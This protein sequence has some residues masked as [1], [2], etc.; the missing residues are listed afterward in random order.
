[1]AQDA[2]LIFCLRGA[3][4]LRVYAAPAARYSLE[5]SPGHPTSPLDPVDREFLV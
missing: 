4:L 2:L 3:P 1:M 5:T